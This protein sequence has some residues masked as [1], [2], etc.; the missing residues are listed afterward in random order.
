M[1]DEAV[2]S[3]RHCQGFGVVGVISIINAAACKIKDHAM[4]R[5]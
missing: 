3:A 2:A 5:R 1:R 4:N